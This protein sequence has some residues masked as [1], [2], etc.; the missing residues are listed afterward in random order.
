MSRRQRRQQGR[1]R[2]AS[3]AGHD[4]EKRDARSPQWLRQRAPLAKPPVGGAKR[5]AGTEGITLALMTAKRSRVER[6]APPRFVLFA[7]ESSSTSDAFRATRLA[8]KNRRN[9]ICSDDRKDDLDHHDEELDPY[10]EQLGHAKDRKKPLPAAHGYEPSNGL[11]VRSA[12][13]CFGRACAAQQSAST[14]NRPPGDR[15]SAT[16]GR[17]RKRFQV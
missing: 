17:R 7:R 16:L 1:P 10:C 11:C 6:Q 12:G 9:R 15:E 5:D 14:A 3:R 4:A 8:V 2:S 13:D